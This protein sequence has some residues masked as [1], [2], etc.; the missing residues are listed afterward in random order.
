MNPP[1]AARAPRMAHPSPAK[2]TYPASLRKTGKC[3]GAII[4][5]AQINN[6]LSRSFQNML[7]WNDLKQTRGFEPIIFVFFFLFK[8]FHFSLIKSLH[9]QHY[10]K[11]FLTLQTTSWYYKPQQSHCYNNPHPLPMNN[12]NLSLNCFSNLNPYLHSPS[13]P[14]FHPYF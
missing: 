9:S 1:S 12:G 7:F 13:D 11:L 2:R 5:I 3:C 14:I 10:F 4:N 6:N 8:Q